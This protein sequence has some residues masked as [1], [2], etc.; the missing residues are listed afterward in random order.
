MSLYI[1]LTLQFHKYSL[2]R[3]STQVFRLVFKWFLKTQN[4][5]SFAQDTLFLTLR[6]KPP[7]VAVRKHDDHTRGVPM[8]YGLFT[9]S[10]SNPQ[11]AHAVILKLYFV[12]LGVY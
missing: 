2:E 11:N 5:A 7:E 3:S 1:E 10:I 8:H 12:V 6:T 9:R 4:L